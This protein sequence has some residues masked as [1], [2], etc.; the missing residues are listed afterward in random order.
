MD[1]FFADIFSNIYR[2]T[3]FD[4]E[5]QK[6]QH[7]VIIYQTVLMYSNTFYYLLFKKNLTVVQR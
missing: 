3:H 6:R 2:N 4:K 5:F 7:N 1:N